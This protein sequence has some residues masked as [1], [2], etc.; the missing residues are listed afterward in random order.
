MNR[1]FQGGQTA[2]IR[3]NIQP[4]GFDQ[5]DALI[6]DRIRKDQANALI[7]KDIDIKCLQQHGK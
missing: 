6:D 7:E 4:T 1:G 3:P 2:D 5:A